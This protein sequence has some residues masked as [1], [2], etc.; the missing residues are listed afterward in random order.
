MLV[1]K[2]YQR[3]KIVPFIFASAIPFVAHA[4]AMNVAPVSGELSESG[5][6]SKMT[7]RVMND[8]AQPIPV[9]ILAFKLT[10][11]E[12]GT[13]TTS[14]AKDKF[15]IYP[16]QITIA[17]GATQSFR[18]QWLAAPNLKATET[19]ILGVN[20]LPIAMDK[21]KNGVQVI[22]NFNAVVN[23]SPANAKPAISV[24]KA[25][26][27]NTPK[28][29]RAPTITVENTGNGHAMLG[30]ASI[31]LTDGKWTKALS[32]EEVRALFGLGLVQPR[33]KRRFVLATPLPPE[34][35]KY[36]VRIEL[37]TPKSAR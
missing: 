22:F 28:I 2:Y 35:S 21:Q 37:N 23:V 19:Y 26:I 16:P 14:P 17:A 29:S 33:S 15:L 1:S 4:H 8:G 9:E 6:N 32:R 34:V 31:V 7:L 3:F 18:V 13:Q 20:Q 10:L 25:D 30:D 11:A 36:Q 27:V 24:L 12:D 5:Q